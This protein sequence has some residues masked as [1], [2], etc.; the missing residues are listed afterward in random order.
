MKR[1]TNIPKFKENPNIIRSPSI[2]KRYP[3][4]TLVYGP[5]GLYFVNESSE[6][7]PSVSTE[8]WGFK[9]ELTLQGGNEFSYTDVQ[10]DEGVLIQKA[11]TKEEAEDFVIYGQDFYRGL[12]IYLESERF[13]KIRITPDLKHRVEEQILIYTDGGSPRRV[14]VTSMED[15]DA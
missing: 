3:L 7:L 12:Y 2:P 5:G 6:V 1:I 11:M 15:N 10:P 14:I 4:F 8:P 13:G 9:G